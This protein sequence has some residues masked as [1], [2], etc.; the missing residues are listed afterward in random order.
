MAIDQFHASHQDLYG[1]SYQGTQ[2]VELVNVGVTGLGLLARPQIPQTLLAG[3]D[4][5]AALRGQNNKRAAGWRAQIRRAN[6][7]P[8]KLGI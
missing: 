5:S 1:Y 3:T 2:L 4:A 7:M 8:F 6:S